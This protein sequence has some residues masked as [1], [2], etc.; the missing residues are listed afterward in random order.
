MFVFVLWKVVA[1]VVEFVRWADG[2]IGD[3]ETEKTIN[4]I[5]QEWAE[6]FC[7]RKTYFLPTG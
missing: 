3:A 4:V 7:M 2:Y 1:K 6:D 5:G